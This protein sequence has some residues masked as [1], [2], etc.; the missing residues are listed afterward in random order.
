MLMT[1]EGHI[2][3]FHEFLNIKMLISWDGFIAV[4]KGSLLLIF[5]K[6]HA[7]GRSF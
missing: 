6:I 4:S 1:C 7:K 3:I 2:N 5:Q